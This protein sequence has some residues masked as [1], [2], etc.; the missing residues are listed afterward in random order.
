M[1]IFKL[2]IGMYIYWKGRKRVVLIHS[3]YVYWGWARAKPEL[4]NSI[5]VSQLSG[6]DLTAASRMAKAG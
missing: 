3:A 4:G 5:W 6:K 1:F 2:F